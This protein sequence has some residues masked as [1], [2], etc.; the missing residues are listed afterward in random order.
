VSSTLHE[1][2]KNV[3]AVGN[4]LRFLPFMGAVGAPTVRVDAMVVAG[5]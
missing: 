5:R 1:I 3:V 2:L 4:D